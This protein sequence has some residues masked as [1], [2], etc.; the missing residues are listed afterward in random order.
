[1]TRVGSQRHRKKK[2]LAY[3]HAFTYT[4]H[5]SSGLH[6]KRISRNEARQVECKWLRWSRGS[7]L[8]LSTQVR[9]FKPGQSCQ[10]F[11]GQKIF[12]APS[13][14]GEVK[15]SI[16]CCRFVACKRSLHGTWKSIFRQNY[17]PTFSPT[18]PPFAARISR[19]VWTWR[20]LAAEVRISKNH[21]RGGVLRVAQKACSASGAYAPGPEE[22]EA[23]EC[24][25]NYSVSRSIQ[26]CQV[27]TV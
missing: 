15:P 19:V 22:E 13:F 12:S 23:I 24:N 10:D 5:I 27:L 17:R 25:N 16:P 9:G 18:V 2:M 8:P 4:C 6:H 20:H 1:V 21:R 11:S 7:V 14:G 26:Y 3:K